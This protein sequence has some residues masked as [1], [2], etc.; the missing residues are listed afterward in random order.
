MVGKGRPKA[1]VVVKLDHR[2]VDGW[3]DQQHARKSEILCV[4]LCA[5]VF[6]DV[7]A[8]PSRERGVHCYVL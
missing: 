7:A 4:V 3:R 2:W 5:S 6:G 1:V 8:F